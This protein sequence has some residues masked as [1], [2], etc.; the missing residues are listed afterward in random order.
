MSDD[1]E[2]LQ[3]SVRK[4][5]AGAEVALLAQVAKVA[6]ISRKMLP[7][8]QSAGTAIKTEAQKIAGALHR[9]GH[10]ERAAQIEEALKGGGGDPGEGSPPI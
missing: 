4:A 8:I 2:R 6:G 3:E 7:R 5:L 10:R 1:K 9:L